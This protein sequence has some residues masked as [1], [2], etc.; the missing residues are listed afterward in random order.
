MK[1]KEYRAKRKFS[2]TPEPAGGDSSGNKLHFVVQK[3]QATSLHYDFRLEMKGVLK[4]WAIPKGP[5]LNPEDRRL[6]MMVED[7]PYD[8]KDFEGHIP[9]GNY[10]AG[11]V[12][13][14]DSGTYEPL[15]KGLSKKASEK[16]LFEQL[17]NGSLKFRLSGHK[18]KG[19]F[20]LVH[21]KNQDRD[22]NAWL[23][24]KHRDEY[25][26]VTDI[27]KKGKSVISG[28]TLLQ[29]QK[30]KKSDYRISVKSRSGPARTNK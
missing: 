8:Y 3:H 15:E 13:V 18:L 26:R 2:Q 28:Q 7:H 6:A 14:W 12:I 9:V 22:N 4:S 11:T 1:L 29:M 30:N 23:M 5:S 16:L 20:A 10:G 21:I 19:E 25:A 17:N 24:I 27:T